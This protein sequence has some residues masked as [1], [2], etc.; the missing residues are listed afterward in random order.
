[1]AIKAY[2]EGALPFPD[3]T[4]L[5]KVAWKQAQSVPDNGALGKFRAFVPGRLYKE[6]FNGWL[7]IRAIHL[8]QAPDRGRRIKRE[9]LKESMS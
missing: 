2:R 8:H 4:I 3:G 7:G 1:V 5:A 9:H 6:R